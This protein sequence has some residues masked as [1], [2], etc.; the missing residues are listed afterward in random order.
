M[1]E[2]TNKIFAKLEKEQD[3]N[4]REENQLKTL[5]RFSE[6]LRILSYPGKF[7]QDTIELF[8]KG[9]KKVL[10]PIIYFCIANFQDLKKR[11]Y[12]GKFLVPLVVP[13]EFLADNEMKQINTEYKELI[14]EFKQTHTDYE[15]V[16]QDASS[17][18]E[19]KAV[20]MILNTT[21]N[22]QI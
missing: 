8:N 17:P 18:E 16:K 21:G 4:L 5:Q 14:E 7:D 6:F 13:D 12:L 20:C 22:H 19:L 10:S 1:L 15:K 11:A 2:L 3:V 9:E